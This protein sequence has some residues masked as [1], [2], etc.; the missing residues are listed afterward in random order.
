[1]LTGNKDLAASRIRATPGNT[2]SQHQNRTRL[3]AKAENF[4]LRQVGGPRGGVLRRVFGSSE[5]K[6]H[7][8][9][10]HVSRA[11]ALLTHPLL[12]T[13]N[14]QACSKTSL[15]R[16]ALPRYCELC[17]R[18]PCQAVQM[19]QSGRGDEVDPGVRV[20]LRGLLC[21]VEVGLRLS[22]IRI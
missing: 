19:L 21:A 5:S 2:N 14:Q 9:A 20:S 16:L 3:Q 18:L 8:G 17:S 1:M 10:K 22:A 7:S 12:A 6:A 11:N 15:L 4:R 13:V